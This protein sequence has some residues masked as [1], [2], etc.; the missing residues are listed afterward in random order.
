[1][2]KLTFLDKITLKP[3]DVQEYIDYIDGLGEN[4]NFDIVRIV[5]DVTYYLF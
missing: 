4:T 3:D 1:M 5:R 2:L